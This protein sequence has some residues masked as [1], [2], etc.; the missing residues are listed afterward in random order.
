MINH[1]V[2]TGALFLCVGIIYERSHSRQISD[3]SGIGKIMPAYVGFLGFFSLSSMAFPGTNS[4]VG[5]LLVLIGTFSGALF[6][7]VLTIPGVILAAAYMLRLLQKIAWGGKGNPAFVDLNLREYIYLIP[8]ALFVLWIGFAP[9]PFLDV[10]HAS[11]SH[12]IQ[13][14]QAAKTVA[15][16]P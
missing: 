16:I 15:L 5:E 1:G 14:V 2:T 11:V 13:Q 8:L 3:N 10:M 6:F 12:L 9:T 4:F 7:G